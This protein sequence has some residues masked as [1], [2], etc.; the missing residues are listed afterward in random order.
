MFPMCICVLGDVL[1][2]EQQVRF[3]HLVTRQY[4]CIDEKL[5]VAL[6]AERSDPRTVFRLHSVIKVG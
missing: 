4:L 1:R 2:W 6:V 5:E 3:R